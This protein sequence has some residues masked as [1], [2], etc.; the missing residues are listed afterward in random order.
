MIDET[1]TAHV[2]DDPTEN[3]DKPVEKELPEAP[4][5]IHLDAYYK[6][7]HAGITLRSMDNSIIPALRITTAIQNL[8]KAGFEPSWNKDTSTAHLTKSGASG[9]TT[10][11]HKGNCRVHGVPFVH[12]EG[13]SKKTGKPYSFWSCPARN[14]DQSYC[15]EKPTA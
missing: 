14:A 7:F 13:I 15:T 6:G 5:S 3:W 4:L 12:K 11:A 9:G 2:K 10:E 8:I 1:D